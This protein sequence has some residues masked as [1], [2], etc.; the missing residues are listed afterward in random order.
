MIL[1]DLIVV[2]ALACFVAGVILLWGTT[3]TLD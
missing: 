2:G 1:E 3:R